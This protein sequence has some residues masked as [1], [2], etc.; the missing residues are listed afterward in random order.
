MVQASWST[1][2]AQID[3]KCGKLKKKKEKKKWGGKTCKRTKTRIS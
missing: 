1:D 3:P 2:L